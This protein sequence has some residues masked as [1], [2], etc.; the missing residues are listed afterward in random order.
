M[1][2]AFGVL[3]LAFCSSVESGVITINFPE[4]DYELRLQNG[5][6]QLFTNNALLSIKVSL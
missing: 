3:L 6:L 4:D 5:N 2:L 1:N